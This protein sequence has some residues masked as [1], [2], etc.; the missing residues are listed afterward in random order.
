MDTARRTLAKSVTW[1]GCGVAV[2]TMLGYWQTQDW[3]AS[4]AIAVSAAATGFVTFFIHERLW[5]RIR[6]GLKIS[7]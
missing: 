5:S 2:M 6:W 7:P 1:Q 4:F 3:Q